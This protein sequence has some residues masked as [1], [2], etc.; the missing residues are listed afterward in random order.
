MR[1]RPMSGN[2]RR[3]M[4]WV[5]WLIFWTEHGQTEATNKGN[6][7]REAVHVVGRFPTV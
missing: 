4:R 7:I 6:L 5:S 2:K 3:L 1:V